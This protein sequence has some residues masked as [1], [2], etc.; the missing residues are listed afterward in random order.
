MILNYEVEH[1]EITAE[2]SLMPDPCGGEGEPPCDESDDESIPGGG[3]KPPPP[4]NP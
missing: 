3:I 4:T 2:M 1:E